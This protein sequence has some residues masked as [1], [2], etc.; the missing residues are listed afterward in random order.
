MQSFVK[1]FGKGQIIIRRGL[2]R[3][4]AVDLESLTTDGDEIL[5]SVEDGPMI[6]KHY[7]DLTV[8]AGDT[9][10]VS[11]RCKGLTLIV[12]GNLVVNGTISMSAR[13]AKAAGVKT[14]V[15]NPIAGVMIKIESPANLAEIESWLYKNWVPGMIVHDA[16]VEAGLWPSITNESSALESWEIPEEG[17]DGGQTERAPGNAGVNRGTG[18]GGAGSWA[19]GN[20]HLGKGSRGTSYSGGSGGG[21]AYGGYDERTDAEPDGG[22]GGKGLGQ[23]SCGGGSG[24]PGGIGNQGGTTNGGDGTG[25]LLIIICFQTVTVNAGGIISADGVQGGGRSCDRGGGGSGG[26]SL[27]VFYGVSLTNSGTIRANGG[28][29]GT[30][31]NNGGVGGAGSVTLTKI[32]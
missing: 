21:G 9:L 31:Y 10:T 30:G 1:P 28:I 25:G 14:L 5:E 13:G 19:Y 20:E 29:G 32:G 24:N 18:G 17:G 27:N 11:H 15:P 6:T 16:L 4:E 22:A 12:H 23:G 26:G 2:V 8:S 7:Q 3:N